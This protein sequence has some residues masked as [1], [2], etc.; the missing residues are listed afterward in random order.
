MPQAWSSRTLVSLGANLGDAERTLYSA[1][2]SMI[3][4]FGRESI[5]FSKLYKTAAVGGPAGQ[6]DFFN[7]VAIIH[8][9]HTA[10]ELWQFLHQTEQTL[11]RH[12]LKRWEARRIDL[13]VLAHESRTDSQSPLL[14]EVVWTPTFKV[15]HP[16]MTMRTFVLTPACDVSPD[17]I[18]PVTRQSLQNLSARLDRIASQSRLPTLLLSCDSSSVIEALIQSL[19]RSIPSLSLTRDPNPVIFRDG[20]PWIVIGLVPNLAPNNKSR[21]NSE[22]AESATASYR[23]IRECLTT[24]ILQSRKIHSQIQFDHWMHVCRSP[25]PSISHWEDYCRPWADALGMT[26]RH[27]ASLFDHQETQFNLSDSALLKVPP[28]LLAADDIDWA[29]H[30]LIAATEAM[31]CPIQPCGVIS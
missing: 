31:S 18:E 17:W 21:A 3:Q 20:K 28:Y 24:C 16:R 10:F 7:A 1:A 23:A 29:A 22:L 5:S 30:E 12:R 11:G 27:E 8:S 4:C 6:E 9:S 19:Q 2:R 26:G 14:P 13:D 15:P 25:D